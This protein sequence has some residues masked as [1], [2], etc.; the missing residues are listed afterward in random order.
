VRL[1]IAVVAAALQLAGFVRA[2]RRTARDAGART[3]LRAMSHEDYLAR[4]EVPARFREAVAASALPWS[5]EAVFAAWIAALP[6]A[7][8]AG[9]LLGG[10]V[11]G[12]IALVSVVVGPT[13]V[14]ALRGD[15]RGRRF[16]ESLPELLESVAR[17]V[18]S[19]ASLRQALDE[20]TAPAGSA[21]WATGAS[22]A[23]RTLGWALI[24]A[25]PEQPL[26]DTIDGWA[27]GHAR[28]GTRLAAAALSLA[29]DAGA[30]HAR[31][32]DGVASTLRERLGVDRE[33]TAL[34]A[35]ARLSAVII[36]IA[37]LAF[38]V[39]AAVTDPRTPVFLLRTR[40]GWLCI[41]GGL[42]LD[43]VGA[44]WM[45]QLTRSAR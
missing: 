21:G 44:L 24:H 30:A 17:S 14:V 6:V 4:V 20:A 8:L 40:V 12:G 18:R 41:A 31:A 22:P 1:L 28:P 27:V 35:Q 39:V 37:P 34:S 19:G 32:L 2:Y 43:A 7:G 3:R 42:L 33:L 38:A 10:P 11:L 23:A 13:V 15:R 16:D 36:A 5:A 9:C 29:I 26:A 45:A 25:P